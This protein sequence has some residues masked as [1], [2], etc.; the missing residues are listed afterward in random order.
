MELF[1]FF[2]HTMPAQGLVVVVLVVPVASSAVVDPLAAL[3][4]VLA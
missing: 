4:A 2:L 1:F 3:A